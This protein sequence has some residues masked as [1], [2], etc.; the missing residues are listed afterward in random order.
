MGKKDKKK[1]ADPTPAPVA[2]EEA[3][4]EEPVAA[5]VE[6]V[7]KEEVA[8]AAPQKAAEAVPEV[9]TPA[10]SDAGSSIKEAEVKA[11]PEI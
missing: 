6:E 5:P 9:A 8:D 10:S 2:T 4:V 7:K 1:K 3:K 11:K